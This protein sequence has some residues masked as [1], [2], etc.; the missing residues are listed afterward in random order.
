LRMG[1]S[2]LNLG[3]AFGVESGFG[4]AEGEGEGEVNKFM[5]LRLNNLISICI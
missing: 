3:F 4:L 1:S 5:S 2:D